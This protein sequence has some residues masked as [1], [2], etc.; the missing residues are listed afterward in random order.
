MLNGILGKKT[1]QGRGKR[2][3]KKGAQLQK[4]QQGYVY[5]V[6]NGPVRSPPMPKEF[7]VSLINRQ[8]LSITVPVVGPTRNI[9]GLLEYYGKRPLYMREFY[10]MYKYSRVVSVNYHFELTNLTAVPF[11][12]AFAIVP[13]SDAGAIS[14][15]QVIEKPGSVRRLVS[16]LGGMDRIT[17]NKFAVSQDWM[18]NPY[19]TRD[20]WVTEPQSAI[21]TP[22]DP[23][24]PA[25][26]LVIQGLTGNVAYTLTTK[27]TYNIQFFDLEI[28]AVSLGD[29]P[30]YIES[31]DD[32]PPPSRK[33][34][35]AQPAFVKKA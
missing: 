3:P 23:D 25:G 10:T 12:V 20:Y 31:D 6:I 21:G 2:T 11:E 4:Q 32:T 9:F 19:N 8:N 24:E 27:I 16:A 29:K 35:K 26:V 33:A 5:Q 22:L 7:S 15:E 17:L 14:L 1:T 34:L 18:G 13:V 28:P 30:E